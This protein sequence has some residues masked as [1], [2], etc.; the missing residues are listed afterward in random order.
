MIDLHNLLV[1]VH[2][3][4]TPAT[5]ERVLGRLVLPGAGKMV[6]GQTHCTGNTMMMLTYD[7]IYCYLLLTLDTALA[8]GG[9]LHRAQNI[10][11]AGNV[12]SEEQ[13]HNIIYKHNPGK[14]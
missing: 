13:Q 7:G 1:Q 9:F 2:I 11:R 3:Q 5:G 14:N 4:Q 10:V 12:T 6:Q 8:P